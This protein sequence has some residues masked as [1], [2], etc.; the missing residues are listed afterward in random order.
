MDHSCSGMERNAAEN[1]ELRC[2]AHAEVNESNQHVEKW[3][4]A[5]LFKCAQ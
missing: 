3:R 1:E 2:S 5:V 4:Q